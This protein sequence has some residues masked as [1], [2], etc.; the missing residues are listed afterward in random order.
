[1]ASKQFALRDGEPKRLT[2]TWKGNWKN[3]SLA[4][5]GRPLVTIP[6]SK[7]LEQ[8]REVE[9][10]AGNLR[11]QL[12]RPFLG[13]VLLLSLNGRPLPHSG[14]DPRSRL[15]TAYGVIYFVGAA[16]A[17][18]GAA[19]ELFQVQVLRQM[20]FGWPA[21]IE[22]GIFVA[23]GVWVQK[24]QSL[25][26]L[27]LAVG[28]FGLDAILTVVGVASEP[29]TPPPTGSIIVRILFLVY[30]SRGFGAIQQLRRDKQRTA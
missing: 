3:F 2:V 6:T 22:G 4:L 28:L 27:A 10:E 11:V 30:M 17:L 14:G 21:L 23:L 15:A 24:R 13:P 8:G 18:V 1:M 20:G 9:V 16:S 12:K 26:G 7:E 19:T 5:D 25:V 29:G